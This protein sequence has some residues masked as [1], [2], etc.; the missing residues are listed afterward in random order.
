MALRDPIKRTV[1][2]AMPFNPYN[3]Y[4]PLGY[5]PRTPERQNESVPR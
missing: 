2:A 1:E 5:P 4:Q 3:P